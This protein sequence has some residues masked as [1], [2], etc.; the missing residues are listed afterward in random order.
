MAE[1]IVS[2]VLEGLKSLLVNEAKFLSG[3]GDQFEH[4]QNELYLMRGYLKDAD[5]K[6]GDDELVRNWVG[7]IRDAA[8]DLE[9][10]VESFVLKVAY[11]RKRSMVLVLK[12]SACI[13]SEGINRHKIGSK[14]ENIATELS[15]LKS[16]LEGYSIARQIGGSVSATS[17]ERQQD[18]RLTYSHVVEHHFV[19]LKEEIDLLAENLVKKK[20]QVVS[21]WGMGGLGKTTLAKQLNNHKDVRPEFDCFAWVCV[22][23][24][25]QKEDVWKKIFVQLTSDADKDKIEKIESDQIAGELCVLQRKKK[26]L[27]VLDDIWTR[28]AWKSLRAGFPMN[29]ETGSR[30]LITTRNKEVVSEAH[31]SVYLHPIRPLNDAESWELFKKIVTSGRDNTKSEVDR[32]KEELGKEMLKHCGGSPLAIVVLAGLLARKETVE[33]WKTVQKNV[34]AYIGRGTDLESRY[35]GEN[36]EGTSRVLALSYESLPYHL[37]PCFLYLGHFPEDREIPVKRLIQLWIAEGFIY[38]ASGELLEDVAYNCLNELVIRCMVQ[39]GHHGST[40]KIKSCRLHDLMRDLCLLKAKHENFFHISDSFAGA[41]PVSPSG[42]VRRHVIYLD[43]IGDILNPPTDG[44]LRSLLYFTSDGLWFGKP[45]EQWFQNIKLLR[46]LSFKVFGREVELPSTIGNLV[47]LRFFSLE[48]CVVTRFPSSMSK[49]VCLQTL[50]LRCYELKEMK[51]SFRN[52]HNV[53][54]HLGQLRHL[55][56][57]ALGFGLRAAEKRVLPLATL[58]NLQTLVNASNC[59]CRLSDLAGLANLRKMSIV[60]EPPE[61]EMNIVDSETIQSNR[62]QW[63]SLESSTEVQV[64]V[65]I[66]LSCRNIYKL[67]LEGPIAELPKDLLEYP[68]LTQIK[69]YGTSRMDEHI[70]ILEQLPH[71]KFLWLWD[72][73][74]EIPILVF[75][76]QGFPCLEFLS[77]SMISQLKEWRVE[78]GAMN[79]LRRLQVTFCSELKEAPDGLRYIEKLEELAIIMPPEFCSA[80]RKGG[81]DFDKIK[82][83]ASVNLVDMW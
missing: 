4:A 83:V 50:D 34:G 7:I 55:Y 54:R 51:R 22:T 65:R 9:D 69:L 5:A 67:K 24:Q 11:G 20:Y 31:E 39:V 64:S 61:D 63:L 77:I 15:K 36:S 1:A 3:V 66:L 23:Q 6:Q 27:V 12:R 46:V 26:C 57:P 58:G 52:L 30:V 79:C 16:S 45:I 40:N 53:I 38:S 8:Y 13:L 48:G 2:M 10:V 17:F 49:L 78:E 37:K 59:D 62:L 71:L 68:N 75:S 42:K 41:T 29:E 19:G 81:K 47:H 32:K 70:K 43:K 80:L 21:I 72:V 60:I 82:H 33:D 18:Y 28:D 76:K 35:K 56:L 14:I 74:L 25:F 44:Q 73:T